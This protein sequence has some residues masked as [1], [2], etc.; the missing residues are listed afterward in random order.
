M[1]HHLNVHSIVMRKKI[2]TLLFVVAHSIG[3]VFAEGGSCGDSLTWNFTNGTLTISGKGPM[4][5]FNY[6]DKAP[7]YHL[8]SRITSVVIDFGVTTIGDLA[9]NYSPGLSS[10]VIS[11]SVTSIG[12]SSFSDCGG[13]TSLTIGNSVTTIGVTAF[14]NCTGLTK[15]T[16]PNSVTTIDFGAFQYCSSLTSVEIGNGLTNIAD[17]TFY[18]CNALSTVT[19]NS[20]AIANKHYIWSFFGKQVKNVIFGN[21]VKSIGTYAFYE[22]GD[23]LVSVTLGDSVNYI[24]ESAFYGCPTLSS[25]TCNAAIP[26][27]MGRTVF[28]QLDCSQ[29]LLYVPNTSA[30]AYRRADQWK[31]LRIKSIEGFYPVAFLNWDSTELFVSNVPE[32]SIPVYTGDTPQRPSDEQSTYTF[33]KWTPDLVAAIEDATYIATYLQTPIT[34]TVSSNSVNGIVDGIGGYPYGTEVDLTAIPDEGY[35]FVQWSDGV[36]ENPRSVVLTCDTTINALFTLAIN[37]DSIETANVIVSSTGNTATLA[38]PAIPEAATYELVIKENKSGNIFCTYIFNAN[39]EMLSVAYNAPGRHAVQ[40]PELAGFSFTV[41]DLEEG[42]T[43]DLTITAKNDNSEV[44]DIQTI[45]FVAGGGVQQGNES[46]SYPEKRVHKF[47]RNGQVLILHGS[48][49]YTLHGTEIK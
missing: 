7:W 1:R 44:L 16:I 9:F 25:I 22:H 6:V 47:L 12:Q 4:P 23:S 15:V 2:I 36:R 5:N 11:N 10:V 38:W 20:N 17:M 46:V 30:Y 41:T 31:E 39:G 34:Y 40:Q 24:G 43:Y 19:I 42:E 28:A 29:V 13:L 48:N 27:S 37:A 49:V 3:L 14:F 21:D 8:K 45:S 35:I 33:D 32:D 26:P 18:P